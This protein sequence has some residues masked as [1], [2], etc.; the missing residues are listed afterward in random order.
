[1][2]YIPETVK[3]G[4]RKRIKMQVLDVSSENKGFKSFNFDFLN[5]ISVRNEAELAEYEAREREQ[6]IKAFH[7]R[8]GLDCNFYGA[9]I[10]YENYSDTIK[11]SLYKF[12]EKVNNK[13]GGFLIINGTVGTGKTSAAASV[14]NELLMGT[15]LDMPEMEL[16]LNTADRFNSSENRE[17]FLHRLASCELLVLDEI[18]RFPERKNTEQPILF[19]LL[20]RRFQNKRPTIVITNMSSKEFADFMGQA[21]IDRI[22]SDRI[23]IEMNGD[24]LRHLQK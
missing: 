6:K 22:R 13:E 5:N 8:C 9:K 4:K 18:G 17:Q 11:Q 21:L 10:D 15:Y 2:M 7:E 24:S 16:K 12:I 14:M 20:N 1:M 19:Y 23:R 3:I